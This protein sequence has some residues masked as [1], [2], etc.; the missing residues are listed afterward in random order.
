MTGTAVT[1]E[2]LDP[3]DLSGTPTGIVGRTQFQIFWNALKQHRL[4]IAAAVI[5]VVIALACIFVPIFSPYHFNTPNPGHERET[6]GWHHLFGTGDVGEDLLVG[7]L[8][9]GRTSLVVGLGVAAVSTMLGALLGALAGYFGGWVDATISRI[10]EVF[11]TAPQLAVLIAVAAVVQGSLT[12]TLII[13][14]IGALSWM[15]ITRLIRAE[16]LALKERDFVASARAM[17]ASHWRIMWRHLLP[18]SV[19][20]LVVSATLTVGTAILTESALS[21]L[22]IGLSYLNNPTWGNLLDRAQDGVLSGIWWPIVFPGAG[23]ILTVLC[24]NWVGDAL[25]DALDPH[26]TSDAHSD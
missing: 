25:S 11:L 14:V 23:I 17:G 7:V 19:S 1:P 2:L 13:V 24:I 12:L 3:T 4:G 8:Y 16:F 9:G 6:P 22:G 5:L 20:V 18:N 15:N 10:T 21:F 26:S